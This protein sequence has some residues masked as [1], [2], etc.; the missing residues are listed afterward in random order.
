MPPVKAAPKSSRKA[1]R[2]ASRGSAQG[3]LPYLPLAALFVL[4][5]LLRTISLNSDVGGFLAWNEAN[6]LLIARHAS[7][8]TILFPTLKGGFLFLETPPLV[9][10]LIALVS[11]G[12]EP[13]V[14]AGRLVSIF[15][16]LALVVAT[17]RLGRLFFSARAALVAAA[18]TTVAPVAVVAGANIQTDAAY[19]A[20]TVLAVELY[21]RARRA[22]DGSMA[23]FGVAIGFASLAKLFALVALP[24]LLLWEFVEG[25]AP[26]AVRDARRWKALAAG[27]AP[28]AAFYAF[29]VLRA[30]STARTLIL[31]GAA[32]A[33]TFPHRFDVLWA[34]G[35]EAT[36]VFS[37]L[38]A[39]ALAAGVVAAFSRPSSGERLLLCL[40]AAY[41][42]FYL[43]FHKHSYYLLAIL[44]FAAIL[45]GRLADGIR[46]N[47]LRRLLVGAVL[48]SS[49]FVSVID[50]TGMKL[51]FSEIRR[52]ADAVHALEE[53][54][55]RVV[56]EGVVVDNIGIVLDL[57]V[58]GLQVW[59]IADAPPGHEGERVDIPRDSAWLLFVASPEDT[60]GPGL[61][62][63]M[64]ERYMLELFGWSIAE[65]H[66]NPNYFRQGGYQLIRTG[67]FWSFGLPVLRSVPALGFGAIEPGDSL[68]RLRDGLEVRG[69][70]P[71][72]DFR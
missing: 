34:L 9:P 31:G 41:G 44:P 25:S 6:Y 69:P 33:T 52:F 45:F 8:R 20:L 50:V 60:E 21:A 37:P 46:P 61:R 5:L 43:F 32:V 27:L 72:T 57:Y 10:Y 1:N 65:A 40:T 28:L 3:A 13:G 35:V 64:R 58:P 63:F 7:L 24:A 30:P 15:F 53:P 56:A 23:P 26:K 67:G 18:I 4:G 48:V 71:G 12:S 14:L 51:G 22:E 42:L 36:W 70:A 62:L 55:G 47:V 17:W 66:R 38:V 2:R 11:W 16:S 54:V 59:R 68:Y 49:A 29:H 39:L 19:L